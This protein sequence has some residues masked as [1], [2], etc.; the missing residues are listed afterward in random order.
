MGLDRRA[1]RPTSCSATSSCWPRSSL[2]RCRPREPPA[3]HDRVRPMKLIGV[4]TGGTFT[5]A[6]VLDGGRVGIGKALT[7]P[8]DLATGVLD[9]LAAAAADLGTRGRRVPGRRRGA[10]PS[11]RPSG[12]NALLTGNGARVGLLTTEGFEGVVPIAKG[13]KVQGL[14][15]APAHRA[16]A[17]GQ[18]AAAAPPPPHRGRARARRPA[19]RRAHAAR[20]GPRLR[21]RSPAWAGPGSRRSASACCGRR[22]APT[23]SAG[24]ASSSERAPARRPRDAVARAGAPASASTSGR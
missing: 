23:T 16:H 4:D 2:R 20:R 17:V 13:N 11:A 14:A 3:A 22:S 21:P 18:A 24:S 19:R 5:D 7:T 6:V 8:G 9:S 15:R 10:A 1:C 12:L